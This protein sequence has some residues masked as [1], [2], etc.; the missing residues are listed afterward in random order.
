[1]ETILDQ[2]REQFDECFPLMLCMGMAEEDIIHIIQNCLNDNKPY[3]P[4]IDPEVMY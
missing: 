2:Y 4:D 3:T 1:M